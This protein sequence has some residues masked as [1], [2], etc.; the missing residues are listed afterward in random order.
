MRGGEARWAEGRE[1]ARGDNGTMGQW[2]NGTMGHPR[3]CESRARETACGDV[4]T[5]EGPWR[6]S[7]GGLSHCPPSLCDR[8]QRAQKGELGCCVAGVLGLSLIPG[9]ERRI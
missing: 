9:A 2:D 3:L 7:D 5:S 4:G 8:P 1:E 6:Q